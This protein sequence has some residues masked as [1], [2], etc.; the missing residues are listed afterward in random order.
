MDA[1]DNEDYSRAYCDGK[2]CGAAKVRAR[3]IAALPDG[4]VLCWCFHHGNR[5]RTALEAQGAL[6]VPLS[7]D[8]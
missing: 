3:V 5:F 7:T 8:I 2:G 4:G 6:I 1:L